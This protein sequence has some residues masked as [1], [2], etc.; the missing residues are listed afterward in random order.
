MD[1]TY[2]FATI[3]S[4]FVYPD[5]YRP[6]ESHEGLI[7]RWFNGGGFSKLSSPKHTSACYVSNSQ[8]TP[9]NNEK[10]KWIKDPVYGYLWPKSDEEYKKFI[11][12]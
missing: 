5:D 1:F 12:N 7:S 4:G 10:Q 3:K 2:R 6:Y 8:I 9:K 11:E